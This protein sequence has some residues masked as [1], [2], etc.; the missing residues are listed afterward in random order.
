LRRDGDASD[1]FAAADMTGMDFLMQIPGSK[2]IIRKVRK[3][4]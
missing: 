1:L 3:T 2:K 4:R